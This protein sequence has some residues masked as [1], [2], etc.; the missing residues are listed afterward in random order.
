MA[1]LEN[2]GYFKGDSICKFNV[3]SMEE[4]RSVVACGANAISKYLEI[5]SN[6]IERVAFV[7][8]PKEYIERLDEM[9]IKRE[10]LFKDINNCKKR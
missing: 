4:T 9:L 6:R 1:N 3:N 8:E 5:E 7:K 10:K 2:I